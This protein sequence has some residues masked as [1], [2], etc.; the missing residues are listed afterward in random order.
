MMRKSILAFALGVCILALGSAGFADTVNIG[1]TGPL[2]GGA[3]KYGNNNLEGLEH[4]ISEINDAGGITVGGKKYTFKLTALDDKYKPA[5][6]VSNARR[7]MTTVSPKPIVVFCPHSGG[8]LAMAKFNEAEGFLMHGYTDNVAVLKL[9]NKLIVKAPMSMAFYNSGPVDIGW[10][11]GYRKAALLCGAHEAAKIAEKIFQFQWKEKGGQILSVAGIDFKTVTDF[12][13]YLTK[14]LSDK[15]DC[16]YLYGPSESTAMIVA[17]AR[18]LGFKGG[19]LLGSQCK[20]DEMA[21]IAGIEALNQSAG[22]CPVGL[23]PLPLMQEYNKRHKAKYGAESIPTSESAFNYEVMYILAEAM[24]KAG[25]V[26][27]PHK[28]MA[29]VKDVIPVGNHAIR[30]IKKITPEGQFISG[31]FAIEANNG[32][33]SDPINIDPGPWYEKYGATYMPE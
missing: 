13:P 27:D 4:A 32:K 6:T 22:V 28:I 16:I 26:T 10:K 5:E 7:L 24:K 2:S 3:A 1:Y 20:L 8:I 29:A 25:T 19:F 21:K 18:E 17:Q 14:A 12:Y 31:Y 30:G 11:R 33:F 23:M 9:G 15:P